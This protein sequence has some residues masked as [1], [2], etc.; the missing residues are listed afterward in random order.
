MIASCVI[1][2][3]STFLCTPALYRILVLIAS[4]S[5]EKKRIEAL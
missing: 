5:P 1:F 3:M 2:F 4:I